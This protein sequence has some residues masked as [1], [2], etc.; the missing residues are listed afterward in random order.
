MLRQLNDEKIEVL[1]KGFEGE[2]GII[3]SLGIFD[4]AKAQY[5]LDLKEFIE[6]LEGSDTKTQLMFILKQL[7]EPAKGKKAPIRFPCENPY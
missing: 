4:G 5:Q 1:A 3:R 7:V 2:A 6:L